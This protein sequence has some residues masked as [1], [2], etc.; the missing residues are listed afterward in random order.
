[1]IQNL[2][3]K[4]N[5]HRRLG[6]GTGHHYN[7]WTNA[8][9]AFFHHVKG[10]QDN[11]TA[12]RN[13][14]L[15]VQ[16]NVDAGQEAGYYYHNMNRDAATP[17]CLIPGNCTNLTIDGNIISS[18]YKHAIHTVSTTPK[19]MAKTQEPKGWTSHDMNLIHRPALSQ[20]IERVSSRMT[21]L[22]KLSHDL[23]PTG[24]MV[25]IYDP[26]LPTSCVFCRHDTKDPDHT[27]QCPH[28][29]HHLWHHQLFA[30]IQKASHQQWSQPAL[31][32]FLID[33]L[34][35]WFRQSTV[36]LAGPH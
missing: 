23:L 31:V 27:L 25:H 10:H 2:L 26:K 6:R 16:L 24:V 30:A 17:V 21:Q 28:P 29:T 19:L 35:N 18:S 13:L 11:K 14:S 12:Y 32:A 36:N 5:T 3:P 7:M 1:M 20:A 8:Y 33:G 4:R 34:D 22:V 9:C 15:E